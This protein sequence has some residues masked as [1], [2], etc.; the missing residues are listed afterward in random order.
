MPNG[1]LYNFIHFKFIQM[2]SK[3]WNIFFNLLIYH[4]F[5]FS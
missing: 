5:L 3:S 4:L 1:I 2:S